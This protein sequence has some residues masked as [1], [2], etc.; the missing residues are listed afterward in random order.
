MSHT[1]ETQ[2]LTIRFGGHVAVNRVSCTFRPGEL[3]AIVGPNGAGKTTYFNL[4]SGQLRPSDGRIL[5]EGNDITALSAPLRTRAGLGR[6]FQLTNLFPNLSVEE[7]VRLAVQAAHQVHYDMLRPWM[8]RGDLI[9]RAREAYARV[10]D[11]SCTMI[12]RERLEG[13]LSPNN[14]ITLQ[15]RNEPFSVSMVW[16]EPKGSEG[17]E[18][19]YVTGKYDGK[20]R[21]KLGG[22]LGSCS[23]AYPAAR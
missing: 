11:Y 16:Q 19:V 21:V 3:T 4:I 20:M 22:L 5:F 9:A 15:V 18:V 1:L 12:K 14:V 2:D 8:L 7:N 10:K 17:Q 13:V 23:S 6:A